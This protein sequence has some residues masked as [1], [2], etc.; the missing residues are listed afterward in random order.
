M[1]LE[2]DEFCVIVPKGTPLFKALLERQRT[3]GPLQ[4]PEGTCVLETVGAFKSLVRTDFGTLLLLNQERTLL[5]DALVRYVIFHC[6]FR[7][8]KM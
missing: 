7:V 3:T 8:Q 4:V 6:D 5:F 1:T 2:F